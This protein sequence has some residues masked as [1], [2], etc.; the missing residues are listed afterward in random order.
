MFSILG[1]VHGSEFI[2]EPQFMAASVNDILVI[3]VRSGTPKF[4]VSNTLSPCRIVFFSG[5]RLEKAKSGVRSWYLLHSVA[6]VLFSVI[7]FIAISRPSGGRAE[8]DCMPIHE[9]PNEAALAAA[10]GDERFGRTVGA[11]VVA[12]D[13]ML[14]YNRFGAFSSLGMMY[15]LRRDPVPLSKVPK[16]LSADACDALLGTET[17][18]AALS[19]GDVRLKDCKRRRPTRPKTAMI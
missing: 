18:G 17:S 12:M 10:L 15:V 4:S 6:F 14:V 7:A 13:Q 2:Y 9:K 8:L 1:Q 11:D 19:A 5:A 16:A 3:E